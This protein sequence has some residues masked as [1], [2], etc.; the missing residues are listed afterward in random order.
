MDRLGSRI[1]PL[2]AGLAGLVWVWSELAPQRLGFP[3]TD[4][5]ALSLQ[6]LEAN[7]E[8]WTQA[9]FALAVAALALI[10]TVLA[11]GSRLRAWDSAQTSDL[12]AGTITVVGLIG[13]AM[14]LGMAAVRL[15]V[16]PVRYVHSLSQ[17]WGETAYL[18]TQFVGP[19]LLGIAGLALL[20]MWIAAVA[21]LGA[22]RGVVQRGLAVLAIFP[23]LRLAALPGIRL[24]PDGAWVLFM[25][26]I[27]AA[28]LWL[29]LLGAWPPANA[30][31]GPLPA[32]APGALAP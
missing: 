14:L 20:A 4:D 10:P 25:V 5:P 7:P 12:A 8:A 22:R 24:L 26:A 9:G 1:A 2:V 30:A 32:P 21:W 17:A 31:A 27:P 13:A 15:A 18:V 6:F 23:A 19:Q 29:L 11:I 16:E 28:F 3:D